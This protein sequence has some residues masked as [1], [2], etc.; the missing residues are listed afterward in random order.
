M[1]SI[2]ID[3][4]HVHLQGISPEVA[5]TAISGLTPEIHNQVTG[6]KSSHRPRGH[7]QPNTL[8]RQIAQAIARSIRQNSQPR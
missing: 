5:Q 2:N 6:N 8:R 4:I 7:H 3:R 1:K